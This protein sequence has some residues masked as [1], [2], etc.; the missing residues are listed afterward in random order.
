MRP[1]K[2]RQKHPQ[3][4]RQDQ[5]LRQHCVIMPGQ[6]ARWHLSSLDTH[7]HDRAEFKHR[8]VPRKP[9]RLDVFRI[10]DARYLG[11]FVKAKQANHSIHQVSRHN[12][13]PNRVGNMKIKFVGAITRLTRLT[14]ADYI[15]LPLSD[16]TLPEIVPM[17]LK[18]L[19]RYGSEIAKAH[20]ALEDFFLKGEIK[21]DTTGTHVWPPRAAGRPHQSRCPQTLHRSCNLT[22]RKGAAVRLRCQ[23]LGYA[24]SDHRQ[25]SQEHHPPSRGE[26]AQP[27]RG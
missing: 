15:E 21:P 14:H 7:C 13:T 26:A 2:P 19:Q 18:Q 11:H 24:A 8:P 16:E 17:P 27:E 5:G 25:A 4:T 22:M 23:A 3:A 9:K 6:G 12:G 1:E 10:I 20:K